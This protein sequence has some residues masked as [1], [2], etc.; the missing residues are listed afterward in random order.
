MAKRVATSLPREEI[1]AAIS[2]SMT[3]AKFVYEFGS[4]TESPRI[5]GGKGASLARMTNLGLPIPPGFV[6]GTGAYQAWAEAEEIPA[7]LIDEV[8]AS[9]K[10]RI[11]TP[12][13]LILYMPDYPV[14]HDVPIDY[15]IGRMQWYMD[16]GVVQAHIPLSALSSILR[17]EYGGAG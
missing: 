3:T 14:G 1:E 12:D 16:G 6:I 13:E 8:R 5:L 4:G 7:G 17:P 10:Y 9:G 11:L 2:T 15:T